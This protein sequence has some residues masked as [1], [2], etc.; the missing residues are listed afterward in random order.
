MIVLVANRVAVRDL[1]VLVL[2]N[3]MCLSARV[4]LV[5]SREALIHSII[6]FL[7]RIEFWDGDDMELNLDGERWWCFE[8]PWS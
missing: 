6:K 3:F 1:E 4:F 5:M 2:P 8:L 7:G